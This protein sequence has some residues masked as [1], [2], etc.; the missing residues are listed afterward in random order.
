V[1]AITFD[2]GI[3]RS[4][5]ETVTGRTHR[6]HGLAT[7]SVTPGQTKMTMTLATFNTDWYDGLA[8]NK[9]YRITLT[10]PGSGAGAGSGFCVHLP[11]ARLVETP[12]RADVGDNHGV[13]LSFEA[14]ESADT[15][16][17]SNE[18]LQKSRF[19]IAMF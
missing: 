10:Q 7:Y 11:N 12:G 18:D 4:K 17:G 2:P 9:R 1:N 13:T 6:F 15:T 5:V 3:T 19:L 8:L 16:G 14:S